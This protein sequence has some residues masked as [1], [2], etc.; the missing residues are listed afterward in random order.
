MKLV[1]PSAT[2]A[3]LQGAEY[4]HA[5]KF[6]VAT[7]VDLA[8]ETVVDNSSLRKPKRVLYE[9]YLINQ[10]CTFLSVLEQTTADSGILGCGTGS[11]CIED[12]LSS[13]GGRCVSA[14][15]SEERQMQSC[16]KCTGTKACLGLTT[17]FKNSFI[18][19]GSC[20]GDYA[21]AFVYSSTIGQD[22]CI[23][24]RACYLLANAKIG[25]RSCTG[26]TVKGTSGYYGYACAFFQ[27]IVGNDSCY[28]Y[29]A[30]YQAAT[31]YQSVVIGNDSCRGDS[32]CMYFGNIAFGDGSCNAPFACYSSTENI[33][34]HS[35]NGDNACSR[36]SASIGD[37]QCLVAGQCQNNTSPVN[38]N[39]CPVTNE[40]TQ[41]PVTVSPTTH[42][43]TASPTN[44]PIT[45]A[46]SNSPVTPSPSTNPVTTKPVTASPSKNPVTLAP[47]KKPAT[48]SPSI[49]PFTFAPTKKPFASVSYI[50]NVSVANCL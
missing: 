9:P 10:E 7:S 20:I 18:G 31:D 16:V 35:C 22:S 38:F 17:A 6:G 32:S 19:C 14:L 44:H 25:D 2:I 34:S 30:C 8:Y 26:D 42:P 49:R 50:Y 24:S 40:P 39:N 15:D 46:P 5:D 43:I 3:V 1:V 12:T 45:S 21:C 48:A 11:I 13:L 37:C 33:G 41:H 27:G 29:G 28:E 23:G 47:S 4:V 36:N